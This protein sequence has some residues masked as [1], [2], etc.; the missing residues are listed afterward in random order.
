M[1]PIA[2]QSFYE[3]LEIPRTAPAEEVEKAYQRA[4][5][6]YGPGSLATY[7]LVA[8]EEMTLLNRRIEEARRV[9]LDAGARAGYDASLAGAPGGAPATASP[10]VQPQ[11]PPQPISIAPARPAEAPAQA[12][13]PAGAAPAGEGAAV[14]APGPEGSAPVATPP[15]AP[16]SEAAAP[17]AAAPAA[18]APSSP[19][20]APG[21]E[22][23][24]APSQGPA[25][26]PPVPAAR[27]AGF[28]PPEGA[29]W[30]GEMLRQAREG[31]GLTL[32]QLAERTK[33][34][35]HH[36]ENV[37][38]DRYPLLPAPVYLRG[39]LISLAK[40]LRLDPQRVSRSYLEL[41]Q[42]SEPPKAPQPK[43][44]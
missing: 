33:V 19:E 16:G 24:P 29:V 7:S 22:A 34:A 20:A 11:A 4:K 21:P 31:R 37:E 14:P 18:P 35:R 8:P 9:L 25:A 15:A 26:A 40:E 2:E 43:P 5:A 12:A 3:I 27:P 44:R 32:H 39:I 1:K 10:P 36:L 28:S 42:A 17:I 6:L 13:A 41:V 38:A 30:N 23:A